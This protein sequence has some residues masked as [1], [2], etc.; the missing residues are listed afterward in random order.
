[1]KQAFLKHQQNHPNSKGPS[2]SGDN[3]LK[4]IAKFVIRDLC[5]S[6][7]NNFG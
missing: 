1:M 5:R 2:I 4:I 7:W 3:N 6:D